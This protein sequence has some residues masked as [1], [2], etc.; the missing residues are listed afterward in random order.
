MGCHSS[1]LAESRRCHFQS[2]AFCTGVPASA[3]TIRYH[4][5][6]LRRVADRSRKSTGSDHL[7]A[8]TRVLVK[9]NQVNAGS[10]SVVACYSPIN[11]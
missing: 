11:V 7:H 10:E 3:V 5:S 8:V 4:Y 1:M 6:D 2:P 9:A